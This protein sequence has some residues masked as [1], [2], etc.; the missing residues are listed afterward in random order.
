MACSKFT[1]E[2]I[3]RERKQEKKQHMYVGWVSDHHA[4]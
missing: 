4:I 3:K 2:K 1:K